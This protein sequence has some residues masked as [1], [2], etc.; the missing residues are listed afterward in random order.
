[1]ESIDP[2]RVNAVRISSTQVEGDDM[3]RLIA[4]SLGIATDGQDKASLLG[5]LEGH[6]QD[7][8][9]A[10]QKT[11]LI[12][13][14]AQNLPVSALEELRMLSNVQLGG[15]AVL[16]TFLLGQPEFRDRLA[17][18]DALE[19]L[20]QRVIASH[21]LTAMDRAETGPYVLHRMKLVG[22][23]GKPAFTEDGFAALYRYSGGVPRKINN[24]MTRV[25]LLGS[26]DQAEVIDGALVEAVIADL[27][28][29]QA[30]PVAAA[31]FAPAAVRAKSAGHDPVTLDLA[32]R[33]AML[34]AHVE[35]QGAALRRVLGLLVEWVEADDDRAHPG[36]IRRAPAA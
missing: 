2:A 33:V 11:L 25:L 6:I 20:R 32:A 8:A 12:V 13:D 15:Q 10:G 27:G 36:E 28:S 29:D 3:L 24:L 23:A 5:K 26:L 22:W 31:A 19:Q 30:S 35:E 17:Q 16:Q 9:R 1:M 18:S 7:R 34:E 21:H 4:Q 14:E